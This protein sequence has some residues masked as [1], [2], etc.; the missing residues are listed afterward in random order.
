[1]LA[2]T[3]LG[4]IWTRL[5]LGNTCQPPRGRGSVGDPSGLASL[6]E[7]LSKNRPKTV[8]SPIDIPYRHGILHGRDL[9]YAN[10]RASTKAFAT[11]LN[12]QPWAA[13]VQRGE[14]FKEPPIDYFDP[15]NAT[16]E[17]V[18]EESSE[19]IKILREYAKSREREGNQE[20]LQ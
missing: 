20:N 1:M 12:L 5:T 13:K 19:L 9:G 4:G 17:D 8:E 18:R 6:A 14:Q 2:A 7:L 11:L 16:W 15:E 10:R 3:V